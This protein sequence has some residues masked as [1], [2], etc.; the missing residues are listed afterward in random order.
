MVM[1]YLKL[2][3]FFSVLVFTFLTITFI[4]DSQA[5]PEPECPTS[6][7]CSGEYGCAW[8]TSCS[9]LAC[10]NYSGGDMC[11]LCIRCR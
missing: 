11:V 6:Q 8:V 7:S 2:M 1:K 4:V 10:Q 5:K 3:I 9:S